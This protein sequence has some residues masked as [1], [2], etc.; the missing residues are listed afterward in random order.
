[1]KR[2]SVLHR[3]FVAAFLLAVA[4]VQAA[5]RDELTVTVETV[6][7]DSHDFNVELA[8]T[9]EEQARGLMFRTELA[10]DAGMLF[11]FP[12]PRRASFWMQNTL[13]PLDMIFVRQNGRIANIIENAEPETLTS[14]RS[15]GRVKAVLEIPGGRAAELGIKAGDLVRHPMLGQKR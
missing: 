10:P 6:S 14:R 12:E 2:I 5:A 4:G 7:G 11:I 9:P 13:I 15:M 1:M 3:F 8:L